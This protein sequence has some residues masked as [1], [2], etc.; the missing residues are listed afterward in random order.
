MTRKIMPTSIAMTT[1]SR[2]NHSP[3]RMPGCFGDTAAP[4]IAVMIGEAAKN[5]M[6]AAITVRSGDSVIPSSRRRA[7]AKTNTVSTVKNAASGVFRT[8]MARH[9]RSTG[10]GAGGGDHHLAD[11]FRPVTG[12]PPK[13]CRAGVEGGAAECAEPG[14]G[15]SPAGHL[16]PDAGAAAGRD[17]DLPGQF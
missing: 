15:P 2:T 8:V 6:S 10:R 13:R 5:A 16:E 14:R 17:N 12:E 3:G 4:A 7:A 9:P 11:L 1:P